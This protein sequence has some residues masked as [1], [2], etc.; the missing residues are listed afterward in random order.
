[1]EENQEVQKTG[2]CPAVGEGL[3]HTVISCP[4]L[5]PPQA[6]GRVS[7]TPPTLCFALVV[8]MC[9]IFTLQIV[10]YESEN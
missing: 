7:I 8:F 1:M 9:A 10:I 2:G 5:S 3:H 4:E 6:A